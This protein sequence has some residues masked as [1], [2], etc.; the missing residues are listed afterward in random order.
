M[1]AVLSL[2]IFAFLAIG[3]LVLFV[4]VLGHINDRGRRLPRG[5][6]PS[7]GRKRKAH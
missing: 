4:M 7:A 5:V 6:D 3:L 1:M 2:M